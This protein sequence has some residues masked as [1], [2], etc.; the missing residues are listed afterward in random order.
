[1]IMLTSN[2]TDIVLCYLGHQIE[3]SVAEPLLGVLADATIETSG[4]FG[5]YQGGIQT[6]SSRLPG[7]SDDERKSVWDKC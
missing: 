7:L 4:G 1:M 2:L 3:A 5:I 6:T